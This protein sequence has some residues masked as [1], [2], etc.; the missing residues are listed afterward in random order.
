M[1]DAGRPI[2]LMNVTIDD[3]SPPNQTFLAQHSQ[4][5]RGIIKDA[6]TF[7]AVGKGVVR[8]AGKIG[9]DAFTKRRSGGRDRGSRTAAAA[10]GHLGRPGTTDA[11]NLR[12]R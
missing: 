7:P 4:R 12:L 6:V 2:P 9:G 8:A 3:N 10:L 5:N 11:T 1:Q